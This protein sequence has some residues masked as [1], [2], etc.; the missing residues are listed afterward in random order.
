MMHGKGGYKF[1]NGSVYQGEMRQGNMHGLGVMKYAHNPSMHSVKKGGCT[2]VKGSGAV[3]VTVGT[4]G[5]QMAPGEACGLGDVLHGHGQGQGVAS[6]KDV[7]DGDWRDNR[8]HGRGIR[9][10]PNGEE[11]SG[12]WVDGERHGKGTLKYANGSVLC[13]EWVHG[14]RRG[15]GI[16]TTTKGEVYDVFDHHDHRDDCLPPS[17]ST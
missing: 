3:G 17:A 10:W 13:G 5:K 7:Y 15:T 12:E 8:R 1:L 16:L 4:S 9:R 6:E 11:Y 2:D 14:C